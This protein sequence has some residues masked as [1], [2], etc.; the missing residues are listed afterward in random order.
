MMFSLRPMNDCVLRLALVMPSSTGSACAGF[1]DGR[2]LG[3][4]LEEAILPR[5][6]AA[7]RLERR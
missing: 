6:W 5:D 1:V 7:G 4:L 3:H 2:V